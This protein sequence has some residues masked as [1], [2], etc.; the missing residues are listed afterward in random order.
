M[1]IIP[2]TIVDKFFDDPDSIRNWALTLPYYKDDKGR[3]PGARTRALHE[4][5]PDFVDYFA[6]KFFSLFFDFEKEAVHWSMDVCFQQIDKSYGTGW[7]HQDE[8]TRIAGIVYLSPEVDVYSGTSIYART[9]EA[10]F[11]PNKMESIMTKVDFYR[12]GKS[13]LEETEKF[14]K[15]V[16]TE[17]TETVRV[18]NVYNRLLAY[19]GH[20]HHAPN[21]F[22]AERENTR[23]TLVF[24]V[25][26]LLA[27]RSP[28]QRS[29]TISTHLPSRPL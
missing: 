17:F 23:L 13:T 10:V 9:N 6:K 14:R 24:F 19:D 11:A 29:R 15:Q 8:S 3:W 21:E 22:T 26:K 25:T 20:I 1:H 27:D 18:N 5:N 16:A 2:L 7:V 28:I 4:I 12:G